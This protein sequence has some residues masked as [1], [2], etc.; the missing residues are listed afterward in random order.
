MTITRQPP[1]TFAIA[2]G[3]GARNAVR[4][5]PQHGALVQY[6]PNVG[7]HGT[8]TFTYTVSN[9]VFT[10]APSKVTLTV[11]PAIPQAAD[12]FISNA[13][14]HATSIAL[15]ETTAMTR[16]R[17]RRTYSIVSPPSHGTVTGLNAATGTVNYTPASSSGVPDS[18]TYKCEQWDLQRNGDREHRHVR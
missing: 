8:D 11:A 4:V 7:F 17:F 15:S 2:T 16:L 5:Q 14:T 3:G 13:I 10:T 1:L 9:G 18:F 12:R 6:V